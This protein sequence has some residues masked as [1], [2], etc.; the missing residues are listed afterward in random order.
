MY[1]VIET[2]GFQHKVVLGE[3][4]RIPLTGDEAGST[5]EIKS[6]LLYSN[7]SEV[8]V[9][10][11]VVE[12]ASVKAEALAPGREK[13]IIIFK[14]ERRKGYH[15]KRGHRQDYL[16]VIITEI[17]VG[18][19]RSVVDPQVV[20]RAR[21]RAAALAAQKVQVKKPTLKEKIAQGIP[22]PQSK[23]QLRR[24]QKKEAAVA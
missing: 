18:A 17:Q 22:K 23:K 21:A 6:V 24:E 2:G 10:T 12:N 19:E 3:T 20:V 11:P 15:V 5:F 9:G 16:E 4:L 1:A 14:K 13:K 7:G 8:K